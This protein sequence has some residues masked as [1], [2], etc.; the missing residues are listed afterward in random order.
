MNHAACHFSKSAKSFLLNDLLL[1]TFQLK[2]GALQF[3]RPFFDGGFEV[4]G[5]GFDLEMLKPSAKQIANAHLNFCGVK[6][7]QHNI[8]GTGHESLSLLLR[9]FRSRE[10]QNWQAIV[11]RLL[12]AE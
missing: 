9:I 6:W 1:A 7:L 12:A 10:D 5:L 2:H 11:W 3:L 8:G 4:A